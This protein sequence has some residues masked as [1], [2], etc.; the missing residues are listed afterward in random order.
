[1]LPVFTLLNFVLDLTYMKSSGFMGGAKL[2]PTV[3]VS[4]DYKYICDTC[5]PLKKAISRN[6]IVW[7]GFKRGLYPG[8]DANFCE[9]DGVRLCAYWDAKKKQTWN[10]PFHR[11]EGL[12]IACLLNGSVDFSVSKHSNKF[13]GLTSE[14]F[15]V[16]KPWQEHAI[17][18]PVLTSSK[19]FFL[20]IDF[21]IRRP[22]QSW[23]WPSWTVLSNSDKEEFSKYVQNTNQSVFKSTVRLKSIFRE[24]CDIIDSNV[25]SN[26]T[27][28]LAVLFNQ[29]LLELLSVF[30]GEH[31]DYPKDSPN[32]NVVKCF[33]EQLD[34]YCHENWTLASMAEDCGL[35][36]TRFTYYCKLLA[37]STPMNLLNLARLGRARGIIE[38]SDPDGGISITEIAMNCGFSTSQYFSTKFKEAYGCSPREYYLR[39]HKKAT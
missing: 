33:L 13:T 16:T 25:I 1:M 26:S 21:G 4:Q 38:K 36:T 12:E 22:N 20:I 9:L 8:D 27:S 29:I 7:R 35:K 5:E 23:K 34:A 19:M 24:I 15:T 30:R 31:I 10:L 17:G 2:K 32:I 18:N 11:N 14:H 6:E 39:F 37:N 3:F 28:V